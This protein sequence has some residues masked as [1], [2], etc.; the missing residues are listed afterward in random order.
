QV[1]VGVAS[2]FLLYLVIYLVVPNRRMRPTAVLP[3][4]LFAGVAFELLTLL[5]PAYIALNQTGINRFG[6]QF[7]FLFVLLAFFY[8]L[9]LITV[10]GA[11][12]IAVLDPP[13][14]RRDVT[15]ETRAGTARARRMGR[16][17]KIAF[18]A[19]AFLLGVFAGRRGRT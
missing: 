1:G 9:G 7:A 3:A 14:S 4:A 6:S 2:G 5:F 8:F 10:R 12:V 18:G 15:L 16:G 19:G 17:R 13:E 11:D